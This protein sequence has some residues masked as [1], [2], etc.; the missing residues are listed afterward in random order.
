MAHIKIA[1]DYELK[2]WKSH[3]DDPPDGRSVK[4]V[5]IFS[6]NL[7]QSSLPK[8]QED[9]FDLN[10][11][12]FLKSCEVSADV[13][14]GPRCGIFQTYR[15]PVMY[16]VD[17]LWKLYKKEGLRQIPSGVKIFQGEAEYFTLPQQCDLIV[18]INA[19]D[20]SGSLKSSIKNIMSNLKLGGLFCM[21]IHMR[22]KKQLNKGH[23]MLVT[24]KEIDNMLSAWEVLDK[25]VYSKC[26][27]ED[28][29]YKSYVVTV[30]K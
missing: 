11:F 19:L 24:E 25:H 6:Q 28:K 20:H 22:T 5:D 30:K 9:G 16:A 26:P 8:C 3:K 13:G 17:P 14:C 4:M 10:P 1:K 15:S 29:P 21:H 27:I 7:L 18:S 2:Y 12:R 23:Q